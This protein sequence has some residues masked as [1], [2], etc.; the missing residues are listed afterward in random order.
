MARHG[1]R[2]VLGGH[3]LRFAVHLT[4]LATLWPHP[5]AYACSLCS[6][7]CLAQHSMATAVVAG[8]TL[9]LYANHCPCGAHSETQVIAILW[10][11][12]VETTYFIVTK[13]LA[14]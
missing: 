7:M 8:A 5:T 3:A 13:L 6:I 2:R 10:V 4:T 12:A 9:L 1:V 11:E 14:L